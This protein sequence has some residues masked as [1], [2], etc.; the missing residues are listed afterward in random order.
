MLMDGSDNFDV[1][2]FWTHFFT[3]DDMKPM[4]E[5]EGFEDIECFDDVLPE[6]DMWNGENVLFC[7]ARKVFGKMDA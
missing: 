1:Y 2:R 6:I 5:S 7:K 4:L 3:S